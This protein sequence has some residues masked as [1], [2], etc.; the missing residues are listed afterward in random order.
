VSRGSTT[1][2]KGPLRGARYRLLDREHAPFGLT[3]GAEPHWARVEDTSGE[4]VANYGSEFSLS[5]DREL[6]E[7]SLYGA[8]NLLYDP[9]VTLSQLTGTWERQATLGVSAALTMQVHKGIFFGAEA[10]YL[11]KYD[12]ISFDSFAGQALFVGPTM[13]ASLSKNMAISA[14]WNVQVTGHAADMPGSLE[15]KNFERHRAQ[16]RLMYNF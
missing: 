15:L 12:G 13:Y 4:P 11:R 3:V 7:N 14:A 9:E 6:I 16:L 10:R 5:V 8:L 1:A 2:S